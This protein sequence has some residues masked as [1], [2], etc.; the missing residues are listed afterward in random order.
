MQYIETATN[1]P[2]LR[3]VFFH[4]VDATDGI[5]PEA[6][7]AGGTPT[8]SING[9]TPANTVNTLQA[10]DASKGDYYLEL[11]TTEIVTP[12]HL[13]L[14]YKSAETAHFAQQVQVM[15]FDPYTWFGTLGG[16]GGADVDYKRIKKLIDEAVGSIPTPVQKEPDLIPISE[17]LQAVITEIRSL[18]I[19][20]PEKPNLEPV[21]KQ[22][23][24]LDK[25]I[26]NIDIPKC[27][28]SEVL[29]KLAQQD[30][31]FTTTMEEMMETADDQAK[32]MKDSQA[33]STEKFSTTLDALKQ[34]I[35]ASPVM[36]FKDSKDIPAKEEKKPDSESIL[37]EYLK[38]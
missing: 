24:L 15:A 26:R 38:L 9:R 25:D 23:S 7:E 6:G 28:H 5:T 37:K 33:K 21:L 35:D 10:V 20:K 14:H 34:R 3:R 1:N 11:S 8:I 2:E 27:D 17:G 31:L 29:K 13:L 22:L 19:P 18:D 36:I 12:R 32:E 30:K 4:L 16:G